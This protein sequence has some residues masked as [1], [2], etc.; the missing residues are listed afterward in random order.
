MRLDQI[1]AQQVLDAV[2]V[3]VDDINKRQDR[4]CATASALRDGNTFRIFDTKTGSFNLCYFLEEVDG[5]GTAP[6]ENGTRVRDRLVVRIPLIPRL[7]CA[8]EKLRS[9]IATMK[10][11][12][13][14]RV[15]IMSS[16]NTRLQG[17]SPPRPQFESRKYTT[18]RP[19]LTIRSAFPSC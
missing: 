2:T 16:F 11:V 7:G 19:R 13:H 17:L 14:C 10:W 3:F 5:V 18:T 8:E 1:Q 12:V 4:V 6:A 15:Q 9:E